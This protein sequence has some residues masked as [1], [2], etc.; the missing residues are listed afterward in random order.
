M[1]EETDNGVGWH[2]SG[3]A[4]TTFEPSQAMPTPPVSLAPPPGRDLSTFVYAI[5]RIEPRFPSL[6]VEKEF[7]QATGR[8]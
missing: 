3:T 4:T 5:G 6:G 1:A 2:D 8:A 7:A